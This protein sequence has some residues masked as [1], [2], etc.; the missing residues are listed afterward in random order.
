MQQSSCN[1]RKTPEL[2]LKWR[3]VNRKRQVK[4][5]KRAIIRKC[6][7]NSHPCMSYNSQIGTKWNEI[8]FRI[9][10][11]SSMETTTSGRSAERTWMSVYAREESRGAPDSTLKLQWANREAA[12]GEAEARDQLVT[13]QEVE[14]E[15]R[16]EANDAAPTARFLRYE[17]AIFLHMAMASA[18]EWGV[19]PLVNP[20]GSVHDDGS[21]LQSV[22]APGARGLRSVTGLS[23]V[24]VC[25]SRAKIMFSLRMWIFSCYPTG[26]GANGR[27]WNEEINY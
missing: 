25:C 13:N 2:Q 6:M 22:T 21:P 18:I 16:R 14:A 26:V 20:W 17:D 9:Q 10:Y 3:S 11:R 8:G 12:A 15:N 27:N 1:S 23:R 5:E 19:R 24:G 7:R 4:K